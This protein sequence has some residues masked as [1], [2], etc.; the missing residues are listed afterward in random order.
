M[1]LGIIGLGRMGAN[2]ARRLMRAGHQ[3]VAHD[4]SGEAVDALAR[5]G[6]TGAK[7]LQELVSKVK[8]PRALWIM[9][10][11]ANVDATIAALEPL[12]SAGDILI[13]GGNSHYPDDVR[14][15]KALGSK[16]IHYLDVGTSGGVWG[17]EEGYCLMVGGDAAVV[18]RLQPVFTALV[19]EGRLPPLRARSARATS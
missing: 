7:S 3:C 10:P 6:A 2:I 18:Q 4:V 15:A 8:A 9:V 5:E 16:G 19:A 14:R 11:A 13:D 12:L 17:L 1:Q